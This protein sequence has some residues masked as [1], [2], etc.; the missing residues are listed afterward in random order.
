LP[1]ELKNK[2]DQA[3]KDNGRTLTTELILRLEMT[4]EQD[5][6]LADIREEL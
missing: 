4:F 6:D 3:A 1:A 5:N 2:L